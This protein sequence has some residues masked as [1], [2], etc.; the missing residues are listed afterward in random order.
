M[1]PYIIC[2]NAIFPSL[3]FLS[4]LHMFLLSP[5]VFS[6]LLFQATW[7]RKE[8]C[9]ASSASFTNSHP[10]S[11]SVFLYFIYAV[12]ACKKWQFVGHQ[13]RIYSATRK[14]FFL[15]PHT[16]ICLNSSRGET[17]QFN[18]TPTKVKSIQVTFPVCV[19]SSSTFCFLRWSTAH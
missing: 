14:S 9:T 2:F 3:F 15:L 4:F 18:Q 19:S 11:S 5:S 6:L 17:G 7:V 13:I 8:C 12:L 16:T 10:S 1:W